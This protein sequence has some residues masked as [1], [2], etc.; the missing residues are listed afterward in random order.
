MEGLKYK[1][2]MPKKNNLEEVIKADSNYLLSSLRRD[3]DKPKLKSGAEA[4]I[5]TLRIISEL[6]ENQNSKLDR[7]HDLM[8]EVRK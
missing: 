7:L 8:L 2:F 1:S 4:R 5:N 3:L 6:L